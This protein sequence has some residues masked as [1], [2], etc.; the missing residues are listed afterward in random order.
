MGRAPP[1]LRDLGPSPM[2]S[3]AD[4]E[5][6]TD[7]QVLLLPPQVS[8]PDGPWQFETP[9][10]FMDL[11]GHMDADSSREDS[12]DMSSAQQH[13]RAGKGGEGRCLPMTSVTVEPVGRARRSDGAA[14]VEQ[15]AGGRG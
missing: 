8:S 5:D 4:E 2:H 7:S 14:V 3:L 11:P 6:D 9:V 12:L 10:Q 13:V 15:A 1:A